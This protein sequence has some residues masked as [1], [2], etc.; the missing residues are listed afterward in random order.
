M[1]DAARLVW[2][3]R[4]SGD[5]RSASRRRF[6]RAKPAFAGAVAPARRGVLPMLYP[7]MGCD[8]APRPGGLGT[9]PR[10]TIRAASII[11]APARASRY[12][13]VRPGGPDDA[14]LRFG[15]A[16]R[17]PQNL[18]WVMPAK[19]APLIPRLLTVAG[20]DSGGGAGIQADLKAFAALGCHG[21][22]AICALTAQNTVA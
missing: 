3:W 9:Y 14:G 19:G 8:A 17:D 11:E 16:A 22:S 21:M 2:R 1:I 4:A 18:L 13:G 5:T 7:S 6:R 20:S 12:R 10:T 15:H